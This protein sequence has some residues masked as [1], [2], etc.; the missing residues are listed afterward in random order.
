MRP[1]EMRM[2]LRF[3]RKLPYRNDEPVKLVEER[4]PVT[5]GWICPRVLIIHVPI[6]YPTDWKGLA[7]RVWWGKKRRR[8]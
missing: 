1:R 6:E 8:V 4:D 3:L 7:E 5:G 2:L